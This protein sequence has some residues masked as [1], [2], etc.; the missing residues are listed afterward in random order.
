MSIRKDNGVFIFLQLLPIA[1]Q[2]ITKRIK[3]EYSYVVI[4]EPSINDGKIFSRTHVLTICTG[5]CR[6]AIPLL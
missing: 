2:D 3:V 6:C 5:V 4:Y 1:I